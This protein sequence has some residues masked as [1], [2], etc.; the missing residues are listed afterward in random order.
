MAGTVKVGVFVGSLRKDSWNRKV[1]NDLVAMLPEGFE[2][3]FVEIGDLPQYSEDWDQPGKVPERVSEYR[4]QLKNLDAFI[5]STPEY[6]RSVP[7]FLKN[8]LD[9]ASRPMEAKLFSGKPSLIS[10]A[11]TGNIGGFGANH[12]LRQTLMFFNSPVVAQ[13]ELYLSGIHEIYSNSDELPEGTRKFF[14]SAVDAFVSLIKKNQP[15]E[16]A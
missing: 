5:F 3:E 7:G 13:P 14:G 9:I 12:H 16:S 10:T 1:A 15:Y 2:A 4:N 6:N 11:S 8:A